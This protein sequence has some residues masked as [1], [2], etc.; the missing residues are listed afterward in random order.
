[1]YINNLDHMTQ[2]GPMPIYCKIHSKIVFSRTDGTL[3][4]ASITKVLQCVLVHSSR[5]IVREFCFA[6]IVNT[7][8]PFIQI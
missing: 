5:T 2:D 8:T 1:M 6:Q 3:H 7:L 4:E